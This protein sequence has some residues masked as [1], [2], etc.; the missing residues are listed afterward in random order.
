MAPRAIFLDMDDT[1][2]DSSGGVEE[3]W[4]LVCREFAG[5]LCCE[6][7]PLRGA[8][9]RAAQEFWKDEAIAGHWRVRLEESRV[10]YVENALRSEGLDPSRA[11]DLAERYDAEVTARYRLFDDAIETLEW[12]RGRGLRLSLLTNGPQGMQRR[13]IERFGLAPYF[14]RIYIEGEFGLGKPARELFEHALG[15]AG[16]SAAEAWHVGDNLY[17]DIGGAQAAGIHAVWIHR[18][19]LELKE[20]A[21][22][23]PDRVIGHLKEL[24][25]A[26]T[27]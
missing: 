10:V 2:L 7:E 20:D 13:K 12:L 18:E 26:L 15:T 23:V 4:G 14:D 19:R 17:A 27:D 3:S 1:I 21:P 24:R 22:V 11:R 25:E 5:V 16:T 8:I 6:P 9:K